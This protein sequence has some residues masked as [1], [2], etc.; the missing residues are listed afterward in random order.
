MLITEGYTCYSLVDQNK[1]VCSAPI[2]PGSSGGGLFYLTTKELI[3]I[4]I[5]ILTIPDKNGSALAEN[6]HIYIPVFCF[7]DW[8]EKAYE[9]G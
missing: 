2:Y 8:L 9:K 7:I 3:G 1:S 5:Q 4:S 6:I